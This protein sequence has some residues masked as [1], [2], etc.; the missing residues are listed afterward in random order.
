[1][2]LSGFRS[3]AEVCRSVFFSFG[4][5]S[6]ILFFLFLSADGITYSVVAMPGP[7][8]QLIFRYP[9]LC[10]STEWLRRIWKLCYPI[11]HFCTLRAFYRWQGTWSRHTDGTSHATYTTTCVHQLS[12]STERTAGG[13][14]VKSIISPTLEGVRSITR[15]HK[16]LRNWDTPVSKRFFRLFFW[17]AATQCQND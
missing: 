9:H 5:L 15:Y 10:S 17:W 12:I 2:F 7:S 13:N 1:M 3:C 16:I 8:M 14:F 4:L 6:L 11:K